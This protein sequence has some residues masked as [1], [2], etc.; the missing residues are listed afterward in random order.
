LIRRKK[1]FR[2]ALKFWVFSR[3][4]QQKSSNNSLNTERIWDL[5]SISGSGSQGESKMVPLTWICDQKFRVRKI[6]RKREKFSLRAFLGMN[7]SRGRTNSPSLLTNYTLKMLLER[8]ISLQKSSTFAI[9]V[10][11]QTKFTFA[12]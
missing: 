10:S 6:R 2:Q 11:Y 5:C 4:S 7:V 9:F 8:E 3:F 12:H 1:N